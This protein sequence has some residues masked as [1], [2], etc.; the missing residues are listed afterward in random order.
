MDNDLVK[1]AVAIVDEDYE[2][3]S[4]GGCYNGRLSIYPI[5]G[6]K[7]SG[8]KKGDLLYTSQMNS[9]ELYSALKEMIRTEMFLAD[10]PQKQAARA[11]AVLA[12]A[13]AT[14]K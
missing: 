8:L 5:K 1:K 14:S 2:H 13:K 10:H 3:D 7:E 6:M 12:I 9:E 4:G 11:S